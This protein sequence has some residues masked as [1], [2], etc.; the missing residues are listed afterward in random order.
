M[1]DS[2][3]RRSLLFA[4]KALAS[5]T[6]ME[7][8]RG[9]DIGEILHVHPTFVDAEAEGSRGSIDVFVNHQDALI[10]LVKKECAL[11]EIKTSSL[12]NTSFDLP[13]HMKKQQKNPARVR[14]DNYS[15][16]VLGNWALK[17]YLESQDRPQESEEAEFFESFA[18]TRK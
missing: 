4:A 5:P 1:Q 6:A 15:A 14:K 17:L 11:I 9:Q 8:M 2:F 18:V 16:L 12:G 13:A 3:G 7:M 10:D